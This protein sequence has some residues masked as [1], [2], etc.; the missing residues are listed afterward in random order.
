[1]KKKLFIGLILVVVSI[2][3]YGCNTGKK[4]EDKNITESESLYDKDGDGYVDGWY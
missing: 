1:M 3:L 4:T 2:A